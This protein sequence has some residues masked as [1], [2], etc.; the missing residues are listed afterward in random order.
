MIMVEKTRDIRAHICDD[1][2]GEN[3]GHQS[4]QI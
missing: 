4:P 1:N 3:R 2:G